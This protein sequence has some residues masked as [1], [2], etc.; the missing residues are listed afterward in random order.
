MQAERVLDGQWKLV[1]TC[2][3]E[4]FDLLALSGCPSSHWAESNHC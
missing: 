2:N 3:S 4:V 1:Y